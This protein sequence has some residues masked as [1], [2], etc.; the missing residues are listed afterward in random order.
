VAGVV[1]VVVAVAVAAAAAGVA[2]AAAVAGAVVVEEELFLFRRGT[3]FQ[4]ILDV[5]KR[6]VPYHLNYL[7]HYLTFCISSTEL[8]IWQISERT[9]TVGTDE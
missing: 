5:P 1:A 6:P 9:A 4:N 2:A 7:T 8:R 3:T